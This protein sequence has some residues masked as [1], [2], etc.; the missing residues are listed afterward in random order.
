VVHY[1]AK[2]QTIT[3]CS[4]VGHSEVQ[5]KKVTPMTHQVMNGM[6]VER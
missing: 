6:N 4:D 5:A 1:Q 3:S 2:T